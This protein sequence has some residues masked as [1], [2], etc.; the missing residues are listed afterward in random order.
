MI[1]IG[2]N[3]IHYQGFILRPCKAV[4]TSFSCGKEDLNEFFTKDQFRYDEQLLA[5]TY[6]LTPDGGDDNR[7]KALVS[8]CN[9]SIRTESFEINK[10]FKEIQK[11]VPYGKRYKSLPAV[12]IARLGVQQEWKKQKIGS[13]LLNMTKLLFL[14]E[15]R[16]GCRYVTVDAYKT[17]QA[18]GFY[19]S[20]KFR[21]M[22]GEEKEEYETRL[23]DPA[24]EEE[25]SDNSVAMYYNLKWTQGVAEAKTFISIV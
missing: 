15:N 10:D 4:P 13:L 9:D 1:E 18:I 16:T 21:F 14:T 5:K 12:K 22:R 8:F 25:D 6:V 17:K 2:R 19:M 7:P 11:Q 24:F 3:E 23:T 20:N